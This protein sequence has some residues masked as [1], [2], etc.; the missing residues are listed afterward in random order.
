MKFHLMDI[1]YSD[2]DPPVGRTTLMSKYNLCKVAPA[3]KWEC[4]KFD[5]PLSSVSKKTNE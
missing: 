4:L 5:K 3:A 2:T 1:L